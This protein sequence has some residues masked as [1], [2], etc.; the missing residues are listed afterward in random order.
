[1]HVFVC[2]MKVYDLE[3]I[4]AAEHAAYNPL[5]HIV[6]DRQLLLLDIELHCMPA[7]MQC[8]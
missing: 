1:M 7:C 2:S 4:S 8:K 6:G 3:P 5:P